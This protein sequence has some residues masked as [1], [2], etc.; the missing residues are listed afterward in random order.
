M[1]PWLAVTIGIGIGIGCSK[2][3]KP[4][5]CGGQA[6]ELGRFLAAVYKGRTPVAT[7]R[8]ASR[9]SLPALPGAPRIEEEQVTLLDP[10]GITAG[11][12][13][14]GWTDDPDVP[15]LAI[16]AAR[17]VEP[18]SPELTLAIDAATPWAQ[19][20]PV[21]N[22]GLAIHYDH[23]R[24][25]FAGAAPPPPPRSAVDDE[26]D[27]IPASPP[28]GRGT[29]VAAVLERLVKDCPALHR[30]FA[31]MS[32]FEGDRWQR[33]I[34]SI[35]PALTECGCA[36]D[37]PSLRSATWQLIGNF[38]ALTTATV[39]LSADGE[40]LAIPGATPWREASQQLVAA[41]KPVHPTIAP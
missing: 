34:A 35:P 29:E 24:L 18:S 3:A 13:R 30:A 39:T 15:E 21:L 41:T 38:P 14:F 5:V 36:T 20:A 10:D 11:R 31:S 2:H 33:L 23:V 25:L 8:L 19:V 12:Q 26:L 40:A 37:L 6:D 17:K 4:A 22:A 16:A 1:R 7:A 27:R 32:N 9:P 28:R